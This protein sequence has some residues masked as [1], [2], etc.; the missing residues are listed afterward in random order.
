MQVVQFARLG[1]CP[2]QMLLRTVYSLTFKLL[3]NLV[4]LPLLILDSL[5]W[6][7]VLENVCQDVPFIWPLPTRSVVPD[8]S[9]MDWGAHMESLKVHGMWLE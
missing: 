2:L 7:M 9:L 8:T 3:D 6:W 1:L 5:Q 4:H